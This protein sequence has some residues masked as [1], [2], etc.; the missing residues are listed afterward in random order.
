MADDLRK[1]K[2]EAARL[3]EKGKHAKAAELYARVAEREDDPQWSQRA[4][5]AWKRAGQP[6]EALRFYVAA[7][8][9]YARQGFLLKAIAMAKVVLAIDPKHTRTHQMVASLYSKE[10]SPSPQPS[11]LVPPPSR[12]PM[13]AGAPA[14]APPGAASPAQHA[15]AHRSAPA[16]AAHAVAL[17]EPRSDFHTDEATPLPVLPIQPGATVD[18]LPLS[19]VISGSKPVEGMRKTYEIPLYDVEELE[20]AYV[21]ESQLPGSKTEKEI[22][23]VSA[24]PPLP[25]IP[26][27]SSLDEYHL[28]RLIEKVRFREIG[29]GET[30]YREGEQ[31]ESM[32]VVVR[33]EVEAS[34]S[35]H[36]QA[37]AR[38]G[39]GAFFGELAVLT[40]SPRPATV[41]ARG[42]TQVLEMDRRA[43]TSLI[44]D[45][46]KV[47]RTLLRFSRDR[48][49]DRLVS[50]SPLFHGFSA[51]DARS[52]ALGFTFLEVEA[53]G[54]LLT[55]GERAPGLFLILCGTIDAVARGKV[56]DTLGPG[57]VCGEVSLLAR[58]ASVSTLIARTKVWALCMKAREFQELMGAYPQLLAYVRE[59]SERR[60]QKLRELGIIA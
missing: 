53:N 33:G 54:Q 31:G 50:T 3:S 29:A 10:A 2:D 45:D 34:V 41:A 11:P 43:I 51:Q 24:E 27:F 1:L 17:A 4:G 57:D 39:E 6:S 48:L 59:L 14:A 35:G 20:A 44:K 26:L 58:C 9:A 32:F 7:A 19:E 36:A 42:V 12:P 30:I 47:L 52:L 60:K 22:P 8:E 25:Q 55:E 46:P 40:D 49:I 37:V 5:D 15:P 16:P 18:S 23:A 13:V 56:L 21:A 38:H 28:R